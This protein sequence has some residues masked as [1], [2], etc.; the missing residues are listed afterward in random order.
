MAWNQNLQ[1]SPKARKETLARATDQQR[2]ACLRFYAQHCRLCLNNGITPTD[3]GT[4]FFE[5][6]EI[7]SQ[8]KEADDSAGAP[9]SDDSYHKRDYDRMFHGKRGW[10]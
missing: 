10:E 4:F 9:R 7:Q 3:F 1:H 8:P 2:E 6:L 5:W